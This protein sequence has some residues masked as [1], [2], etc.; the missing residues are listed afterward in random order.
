MSCRLQYGVLSWGESEGILPCGC[1]ACPLFARLQS[2]RCSRGID[3]V[4]QSASKG[5]LSPA[6]LKFRGDFWLISDQHHDGCPAATAEE[7]PEMLR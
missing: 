2:L 4:G 6:I 5:S 7:L 3:S 1:Q